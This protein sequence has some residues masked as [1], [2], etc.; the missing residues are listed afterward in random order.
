MAIRDLAL[1]VA[2]IPDLADAARIKAGELI[3][4]FFID[5]ETR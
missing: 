3:H 1:A 5:A 2:H 4:T